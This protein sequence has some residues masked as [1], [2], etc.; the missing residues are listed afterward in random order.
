MQ[1][2]QQVDIGLAVIVTGIPQ[3]DQGGTAINGMT[4]KFVQIGQ[5]PTIIRTSQSVTIHHTVNGVLK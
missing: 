5:C 2:V 3:N 4:N 1:L